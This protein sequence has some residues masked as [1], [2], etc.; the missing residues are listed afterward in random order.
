VPAGGYPQICPSRAGRFSNIFTLDSPRAQEDLPEITPRH[1]PEMP[2]TVVP[3]DAP[4][5]LLGRSLLFSALA[6]ACDRG[7]PVPTSN[8][9]PSPAPRRSPS[10]TR[11]WATSSPTCATEPLP[12][13]SGARCSSLRP[14][15]DA[16]SEGPDEHQSTTYTQLTTGRLVAG[17]D[18]DRVADGDVVLADQDLAHDE[19]DDLLALLDGVVLGVDGQAGAEAVERLDE[20]EVGLGVVK[21]GVE[22]VQLGLQGG[23]AFA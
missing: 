18:R 8:R 2:D 21:L 12:V 16:F 9:T 1:V 23:L 6:M 3:L 17:G 14:F 19:P 10:P 11:S 13:S 5:G 7:L 20:L 22:R 4:L 15:S